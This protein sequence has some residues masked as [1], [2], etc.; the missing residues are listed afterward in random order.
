MV[1]ISAFA[2]RSIFQ[3]A[4]VVRNLEDALER[5]SAALDATPW[6]CWTL[7]ADG[8]E[9]T[10][11]RGSPTSFSSRLALNDSSPQL[12]LIEPL[13]GPSAHQEWLDKRG[14]GPH[15]VGIVVDSVPDVVTQMAA[16]GYPLVHRGTGLGP[17]RDGAWA[18]FDT[19]DALGLMIEAVE[20]PTNMP[21]IEFIWPAQAGDR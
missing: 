5:Y 4:F 12:E 20:P 3:L 8:H 2:G 16:A 6:R 14:E 19:T 21:P 7:G 11:Y 10:E 18:Y 17:Q 1:P 9:E 15:H 13:T